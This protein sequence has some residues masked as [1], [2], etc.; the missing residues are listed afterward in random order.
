MLLR[1]LLSSLRYYLL[2]PFQALSSTRGDEY[3]NL[4]SFL[5]WAG[6]KIG[7]DL[8]SSF[9][10]TVTQDPNDIEAGQLAGQIK[11]LHA[12]RCLLGPPVESLIILDRY[13]WLTEELARDNA[14]RVDLINLFDQD[15]G[16]GRNRKSWPALAP[17]GVVP[18]GGGSG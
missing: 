17:S 3:P 11:T 4:E 8:L 7:R 10:E 12:L 16:S 14:L 1:S 6:R 5:Y 2:C 9:K 15:I 18:R 13:L